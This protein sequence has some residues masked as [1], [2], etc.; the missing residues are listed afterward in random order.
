LLVR[1]LTGEPVAAGDAD[2]AALECLTTLRRQGEA[3]VTR[4]DSS[5]LFVASSPDAA[6][7][8]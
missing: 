5:G 3:V 7:R 6:A 4:L 2:R 1:G 8:G